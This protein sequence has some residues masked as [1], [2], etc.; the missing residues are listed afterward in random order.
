MLFS[1]GN[2]VNSE[3]MRTLHAREVKMCIIEL[4]ERTGTRLIKTMTSSL[5]TQLKRYNTVV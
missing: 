4:T 3:N 1:D 5:I 2:Y